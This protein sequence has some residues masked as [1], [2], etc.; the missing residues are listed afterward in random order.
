[1]SYVYGFRLIIFGLEACCCRSTELPQ[2]SKLMMHYLKTA[3]T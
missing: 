1:M 2:P 3:D